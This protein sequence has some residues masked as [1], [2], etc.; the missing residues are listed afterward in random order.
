MSE[1]KHK[2]GYELL[3][4]KYAALQAEK[5]ILVQTAQENYCRVE[6]ERDEWKAMYEHLEN[7]VEELRK[8][9]ERMREEYRHF[10]IVNTTRYELEDRNA[11]LL[12]HCPFWVRWMYRRHFEKGGKE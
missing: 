5:E 11:F 2:G 4:E 8:V 1:K 12:D 7:R 3:K 9:N 6:R 10:N